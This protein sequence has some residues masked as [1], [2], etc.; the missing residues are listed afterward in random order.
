MLTSEKFRETTQ[1]IAS[2][3]HYDW[4]MDDDDEIRNTHRAKLAK[5]EQ[6][7]TLTNGGWKNEDRISISGCFP[8]PVDGCW[9][10][11]IQS[12]SITVTEKKDA[13]TIVKDMQ[14]RLI[15]EYIESLKKVINS[16]NERQKS[17]ELGEAS[18]KTV[19]DAVGTTP[20]QHSGRRSGEGAVYQYDFH[21]FRAQY[22]YNGDFKVELSLPVADVL[23]L[24]AYLKNDRL[25]TISVSSEDVEEYGI[26]EGLTALETQYLVDNLELITDQ[27]I[28]YVQ[29]TEWRRL[30]EEACRGYITAYRM[31]EAAA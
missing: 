6:E 5:Q 25:S 27:V 1:R 15:P 9:Y 28:D 12:P 16:N 3:L 11:G 2:Y 26:E 21:G 31:K 23:K 18:L 24:I 17:I 4:S 14:R 30:F 22:N 8:R 13:L 20:T 7:I 10:S 29:D 19:A